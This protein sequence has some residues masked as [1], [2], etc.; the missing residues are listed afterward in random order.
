MCCSVV[1]GR[2]KC[3]R[4]ITFSEEGFGVEARSKFSQAFLQ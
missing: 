4:Y 2:S 1:Q 3:Y